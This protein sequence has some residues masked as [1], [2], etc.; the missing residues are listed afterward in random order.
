MHGTCSPQVC[1]WILIH[2]A[3][4]RI[5]CTLLHFSNIHVV[6]QKKKFVSRH[7]FKTTVSQSHPNPDVQNVCPVTKG[8]SYNVN[9]CQIK[10]SL[11]PL[12]MTK[13]TKV[14]NDGIFCLAQLNFISH[15]DVFTL[16]DEVWLTQKKYP[17]LY[18][19]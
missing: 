11:R 17:Y 10:I 18:Y 15:N 14:L 13:T 7:C 16:A 1:F 4:V 2:V 12:V 8:G 5:T 6:I 9:Y 3:I 19:H